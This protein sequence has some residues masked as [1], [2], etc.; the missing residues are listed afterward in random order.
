MT[1][2]PQHETYRPGP[3]PMFAP[4]PH[5]LLPGL[6]KALSATGYALAWGRPADWA[7]ELPAL[8]SLLGRELGRYERIG[9]PEHRHRFAASRMLLKHAAAAALGAEPEQLEL[10][11]RPGGRPYVRG[12]DQLEVS[13]SHTGRMLVVAV[14]QLGLVGVDVEATGRPVLGSPVEGDICIPREAEEIGRLPLER[15]NAALVRL[16]TLKEAYGKALGFGMRLPFTSFGFEPVGGEGP[17]RLLRADGVP[18]EQGEWSFESHV[19]DGR[20][21]ASAAISRSALGATRDTQ[22]HT[23]LDGELAATVLAAAA[24]HAGPEPALDGAESGPGR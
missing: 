5:A 1:T 17:G 2:A 14:S 24:H 13:L 16:W 3:D 11:R 22:A 21:T 6:R 10:A 20:Y 8:E 23:M 12:C 15:R 19:L 4:G 18:V 7:P 9:S